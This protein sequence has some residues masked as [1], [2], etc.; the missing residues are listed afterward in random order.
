MPD[1]V[2][3]RA[4]GFS[5][6]AIRAATSAPRLDQAPNAVPIYQ[7]ATFSSIDSEELGDILADTRPGYAYSRIDNPTA[8]ALASVVAELEGAEAGFSFGSGMAAV[9]AALLSL[10]RAG[11]QV[12]ATRA[13]YGSTR[14]LLTNVFGRLGVETVFVDPTDADAVEA[15][16]TPA[17]RLLYLETI[18]NPTIVVPDLALLAE[19]AHRRGIPVVVDNTFASPYLCRPLEL[20]ADLVVESCTKWLGGHSDLIAG[21]VAGPRERI[22]AVR[23]TATETGGIVSPLVAFLVLRGIE[24]LAVRMERHSASARAL[25]AHL[26]A[27]GVPRQVFY[28]ALPSHPQ[29]EVAGRQLRTGGG[30]LALDLGERGAAAAFLDALSLPQRTASLGSVFTI[31]I[32]PPSTSH[33]QLDDAALAASGIPAGLVR[34]SVGLEDV[35]DLIADVGA[36]L[37]AARSAVPA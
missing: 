28:P 4:Q 7:T 11:D 22:A 26:E 3:Q 35:E 10:L 16:F 36:G 37:E 13:V 8:A 17:T 1:D 18:S 6:R 20:G 12:V 19:L 31:A 2:T 9:H 25:A 33:R 30:M 15:A 27:T 21:V 29:H 24:T 34:V 32:H 5:T 14:T 23:E